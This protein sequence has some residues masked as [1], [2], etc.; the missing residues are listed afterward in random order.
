MIGIVVRLP[1]DEE[2]T[3]LDESNLDSDRSDI[4]IEYVVSFDQLINSLS[5]QGLTFSK[6]WSPNV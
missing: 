3:T 4:S 2:M 1:P 6:R 5:S